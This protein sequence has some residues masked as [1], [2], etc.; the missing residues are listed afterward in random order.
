MATPKRRSDFLE[1][2]EGKETRQKLQ[3]MALS[4]SYNTSPSYSVNSA[5]YPD[6][7]IPFVDKHMN[8]LI[9]HPKLEAGKYLANLR[10]MVRIR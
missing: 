4:S 10:L 2:E 8:Y 7:L 5:L 6:N 3:H 9:D 1:S